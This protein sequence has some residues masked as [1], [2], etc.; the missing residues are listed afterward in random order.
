MLPRI[1]YPELILEVN[2][3]TGFLDAM[4]H[5]SGSQARRD[6]LDLSLAALLVA[7][8]CNIGLTPVAKPGTAALGESRLV[9]VE[10]GYFHG[11]GIGKAS[12]ILV[13]KQA[14]IEITAD[15]GAAWSPPPTGCGS[16]SPSVPCT[17][18]RLRCT[19]E[20]GNGRAARPG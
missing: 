4:P 12:A 15:W 6:D 19:S 14:G 13:D 17:R 10:K 2:A 11:E 1:D 16:S 18:G 20:S 9:G 7:R 5:I 3:R 8:S